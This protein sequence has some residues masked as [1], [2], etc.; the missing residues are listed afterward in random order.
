MNRTKNN[1]DTSLLPLPII[2]EAASGNVGAI[3]KVLKHFEGYIV[4]LSMRRLFDENGNLHMIVDDDVRRTLET[5]LI[6]K[7]LQFDMR[8][9]AA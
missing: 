5:K 9:A 1:G 6:V 3:N 2:A 8:R 4:A 7:L